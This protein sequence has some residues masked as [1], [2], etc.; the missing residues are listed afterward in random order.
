MKI[1]L[2]VKLNFKPIN[3]SFIITSIVFL[4]HMDNVKGVKLELG[5]T[6]VV[7]TFLVKYKNPTQSLI[8]S[9]FH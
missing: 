3:H 5:K 1:E 2:K 6:E 7:Q 4:G 8:F 9:Y